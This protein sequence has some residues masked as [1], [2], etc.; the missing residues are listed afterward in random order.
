[1]LDP[2]RPVAER[3]LVLLGCGKMGGAM[4]RGWLAAG[5]PPGVVSVID[6]AG[7]PDLAETGVSVNGALP[8][9]PAVAVL[10]VKPQMMADALPQVAALAGPDTL[11]LSIAA[12]LP[13]AWFESRLAPGTPVVR[14]MPNTPAAVGRGVTALIGNAAASESLGLAAALCGTVGATVTLEN[15]SQMDAVTALSGGG[16]AY[17]FHMIEA[18]AQAGVAAGLPEE[19]ST[20]LA[21]VTVCGA[22]ELA[23]G[24]EDSAETLR[25]NVTSPGGTTAEALKVLM[26]PDSG[27]PPLMTKAVAAAAARSRALADG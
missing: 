17:V 14:A 3:G 7:A 25:V 24:S 15:E 2:M 22:G 10:A 16:P 18:M 23:W 13:I 21:R 6:P 8:A 1:M 4:L 19:L 5:L 20:T 11:F 26:D 12:G 9:A 27:L